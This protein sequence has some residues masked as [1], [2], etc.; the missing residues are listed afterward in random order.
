MSTTREVPFDSLAVDG[1]YYASWSILVLNCIWTMGPLAEKIVVASIL[2]PHLRET[3]ID[4][5]K[6]SLE[7]LECW[8]CNS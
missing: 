4:L 1:S 6:S 7:D 3:K 2:P 5:S 8:Q